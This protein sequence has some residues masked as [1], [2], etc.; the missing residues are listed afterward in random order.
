MAA[1]H[2]SDR[3]RDS[4]LAWPELRGGRLALLGRRVLVV[5]ALV[6]AVTCRGCAGNEPQGRTDEESEQSSSWPCPQF[7]NR[8]DESRARVALARITR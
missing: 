6:A 7:E 8:V 3:D 4:H 1:V 2:S 5:V